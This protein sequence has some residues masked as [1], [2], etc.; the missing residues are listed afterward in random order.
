MV[1]ANIMLDTK[2]NALFAYM[3]LLFP[4]MPA[5]NDPMIV[6]EP[7]QKKIHAVTKPSVKRFSVF[8]LLG[9]FSLKKSPISSI[10]FSIRISSPMIVPSAI[11]IMTH[12]I[13]AV[14]N[15]L[16]NPMKMVTSAKAEITAFVNI[17]FILFLK[18]NP[19]ALPKRTVATFCSDE[20]GHQGY[21]SSPSQYSRFCFAVLALAVTYRVSLP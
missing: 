18:I 2:F 12:K 21:L 7:T 17:S 16:L 19:S 1:A 13:S 14:S 4:L 15:A 3:M 9:A 5:S 11:Q 10:P 8:Y 20:Y 6:I